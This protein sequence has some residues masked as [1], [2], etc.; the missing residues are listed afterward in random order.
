MDSKSNGV[1]GC[2]MMEFGVE[3]FLCW[4]LSRCFFG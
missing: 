2:R 3:E 4:F 1:R